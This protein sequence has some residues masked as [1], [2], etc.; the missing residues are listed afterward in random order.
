MK[1][2]SYKKFPTKK[3]A[4]TP[5]FEAKEQFTN[6]ALENLKSEKE[7]LINNLIN[8]GEFKTNL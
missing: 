8:S 6:S 5:R 2:K 1:L 7:H 4:R 3:I